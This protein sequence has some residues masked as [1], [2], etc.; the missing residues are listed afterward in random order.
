MQAW[1][2]PAATTDPYDLSLAGWDDSSVTVQLNPTE[3]GN[4][5]QNSFANMLI[6]TPGTASLSGG[7]QGLPIPYD[8]NDANW[9]P[10]GY[11][12]ESSNLQTGRDHRIVFYACPERG[13]FS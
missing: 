2:I 3:I 4:T 8:F 6:N 13:L 12:F 10:K 5:E 1:R 9:T 11:A 7:I